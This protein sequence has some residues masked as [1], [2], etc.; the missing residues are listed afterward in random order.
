MR[1]L[2]VWCRLKMHRALLAVESCNGGK[3]NGARP[4]LVPV[5]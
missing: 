1:S 3:A 2:L 4:G 5:V